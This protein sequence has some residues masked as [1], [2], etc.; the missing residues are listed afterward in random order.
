MNVQ[1]SVESCPV[2]CIYWVDRE[3]LALL[4]FLTQPQPKQGYGVY[5]Q[6]WEKPANVFMAAKTLSKQLRQQAEQNHNNGKCKP[7]C[8]F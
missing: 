2:N 3:E 6:G 7:Y 8:F 5:G 1:V 4:E